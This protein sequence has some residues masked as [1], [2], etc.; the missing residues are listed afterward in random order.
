[1]VCFNVGIQYI[2]A[3]KPLEAKLYATLQFQVG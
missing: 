3:G 2:Q 1:M